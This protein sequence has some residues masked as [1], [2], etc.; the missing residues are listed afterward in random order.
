MLC[1][2]RGTRRDLS[3]C[4]IESIRTRADDDGH[5]VLLDDGADLGEGGE[6]AVVPPAVLLLSVRE[7]EV[8]VQAH[9]DPVV[10]LDVLQV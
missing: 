9:G 8:A 3:W 7:I 5:G 10:L 2:D 4:R 1:G 6:A